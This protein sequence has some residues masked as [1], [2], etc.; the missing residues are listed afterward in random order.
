MNDGSAAAAVSREI[1]KLGE[2]LAAQGI[3]VQNDHANADEGSRDRLY[4][5]YGYFIGLKRALAL[6]TKCGQTLH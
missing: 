3:D 1:V 5:H 6:L 2:W 4:L